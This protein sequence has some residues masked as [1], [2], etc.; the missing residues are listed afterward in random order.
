MTVNVVGT[1]T[2][3]NDSVRLNDTV[4]LGLITTPDG[5]G[6][7]Y[8]EDCK[9]GSGTAAPFWVTENEFAPTVKDVVTP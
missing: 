9:V 7:T 4:A 5:I 2:D 3:W 8:V 1:V 6:V